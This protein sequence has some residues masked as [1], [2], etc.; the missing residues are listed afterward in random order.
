MKVI[1]VS[2]FILL[3]VT[4]SCSVAIL[5]KSR[6]LVYPGKRWL[7]KHKYMFSLQ[8]NVEISY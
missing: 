6:A 7:L 1:T 2:T 8:T 3:R 5:I 4:A